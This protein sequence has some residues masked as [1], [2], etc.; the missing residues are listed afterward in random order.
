MSQKRRH[1]RL[2]RRGNRG[3]GFTLVELLVVIA[4]I[5]ILASLLLPAVARARSRARIVRCKSNLREIG[6][7][8]EFYKNDNPRNLPP[9][10]LTL[11]I[12]TPSVNHPYLGDPNVLIC[13]EDFSSGLE[14]GRPDQ[15]RRP[16]DG[17][18]ISQFENADIDNEKGAKNS[19]DGGI[20]CSYLY[21]F[22]CEE[23]EWF[24]YDWGNP[25]GF[26]GPP[27]ALAVFN[28]DGDNK[29]SWYEIK[30]VQVKGATSERLGGMDP[31]RA[32]RGYVPVVRCFWHCTWDT[33]D[34]KDEV[35]SLNYANAVV[36]TPPKW[37][38]YY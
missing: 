14:G 22:N 25:A 6:A 30:M 29:F 20:N 37:E 35:L 13:P 36:V 32:Y 18:I 15:L 1:Q 2:A 19:T 24:T 16:D 31:W 5:S 7:A 3:T 38:D 23:C 4:V 27:E 11:L 33:I 10:W 26:T 17:T 9:P 34:D 28:P 12:R 8:I 21:E